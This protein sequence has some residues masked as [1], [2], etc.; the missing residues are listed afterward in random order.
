MGAFGGAG[1][2]YISGVGLVVCSIS[3]KKSPLV[4]YARKHT[5]RGVNRQ[6]IISNCLLRRR[7]HNRITRA[8]IKTLEEVIRKGIDGHLLGKVS[9]D[10]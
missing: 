10:A 2:A 4:K 8:D 3:V 6:L 1:G 7:G 5:T 9:F